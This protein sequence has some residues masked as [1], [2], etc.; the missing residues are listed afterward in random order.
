MYYLH[1]FHYFYAADFKNKIMIAVTSHSVCVCTLHH[2]CVTGGRQHGKENKYVQKQSFPLLSACNP[3]QGHRWQHLRNTSPLW[4][5]WKH[6]NFL[7]PFQ[8]QLNTT[9]FPTLTSSETESLH[10]LTENQRHS[11][12]RAG[13]DVDWEERNTSFNKAMFLSEIFFVTH[14]FG[15]TTVKEGSGMLRC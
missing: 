15:D 4:F 8:L 12:R 14:L 11:W 10:F 5:I 2:T 7:H 6:T 1:I 13:E 9:R 3:M